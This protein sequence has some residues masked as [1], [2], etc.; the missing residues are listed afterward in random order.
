MA[1]L[2]LAVV[3]PAAAGEAERVV[4]TVNGT[5]ITV[6]HVAVLRDALPPQYRQMP[7]DVLFRAI[8]DQLIRQTALAQAAEPGIGPRDRVA[9]ENDRR[10]YLAG[11]ALQGTAEAAVS[12]AALEEAYRL[13]FAEAAPTIEYNAAHILVA[14]ED[15]ARAIRVQIEAGA[16]FADMARQHSTDGAGAGGGSLGWFG[17]GMMVK[18]FEDAVVAMQPGELSAPIQTQFGWHLV[19]LYETRSAAVPALAQ[20]RDE[21]AQELERAAVEQRIA[22]ITAAATVERSDEGIDPA[23]MRSQTLFDN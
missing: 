6:G 4:A 2:A 23:L 8:V 14:T 16:D 15:E 19:K 13:R 5:P 17:P 18:P 11:V 10:A 20:V 7:D 22:E 21:L 12:D 3:R 9:M 1:V